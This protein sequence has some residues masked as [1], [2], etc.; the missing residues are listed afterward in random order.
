MSFIL[1]INEEII[2]GIFSNYFSQKDR[3]FVGSPK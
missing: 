1:I 3:G 2:L